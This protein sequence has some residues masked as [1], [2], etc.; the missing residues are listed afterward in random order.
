MTARAAVGPPVERGPKA[1]SSRPPA[2]PAH[3]RSPAERGALA[4]VPL[5]ALDLGAGRPR[6]LGRAVARAVV[7]HHHPAHVREAAGHH[8]ADRGGAIEGGD[9]RHQVPAHRRSLPSSSPWQPCPSRDLVTSFTS[10][11]DSS[12]VDEAPRRV[13][14]TARSVELTR[15]ARR[16]L[17]GPPGPG[18][19][20][21][22][23]CRHAHRLPPG[24]Q[25]GRR[26]GQAPALRVRRAAARPL[27]QATVD[28]LLPGRHRLHRLRPG[29]GLPLPVGAGD[30]GRAA[31][32]CSGR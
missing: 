21:P 1:A 29:G 5:Q 20:H 25:A 15:H 12:P 28:R 13:G 24:R 7:D 2:P 16:L 14:A 23:G 26:P 17:P 32:R 30:A 4:L 31:G 19:R 18:R 11:L 8:P 22:G 27:A 10:W 9:R 3:A 6:R